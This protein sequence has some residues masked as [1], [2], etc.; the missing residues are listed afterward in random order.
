MVNNVIGQG[1]RKQT[2]SL[3]GDCKALYLFRR[4]QQY[5]WTVK[6]Y[7]NS[8]V[9]FVETYHIEMHAQIFKDA[10]LRMFTATLLK[11]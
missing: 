7:P 6:A 3:L 1:T 8:E 5:L 10:C 2:V 4:R 11:I 9:L